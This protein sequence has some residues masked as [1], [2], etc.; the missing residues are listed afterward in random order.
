MGH[1]QRL[2]AAYPTQDICSS[3][4]KELPQ[5]RVQELLGKLMSFE[6]EVYIRGQI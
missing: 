3:I 6:L 2:D 1:M 4:H 5:V